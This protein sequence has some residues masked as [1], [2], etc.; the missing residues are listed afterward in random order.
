MNHSFPAQVAARLQQE[1]SDLKQELSRVKSAVAEHGGEDF[2]NLVEGHET[3]AFAV[4]AKRER[5]H[6]GELEARLHH[7]TKEKEVLD[8]VVHGLRQQL[9]DHDRELSE[10]ARAALE[11]K[12]RD[13]E[14]KISVETNH[15]FRGS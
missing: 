12:E 7:V 8:D 14:A 3:S 1:V 15:W 11:A 5:E 13:C 10:K 4:V 6:S 2:A 9:L